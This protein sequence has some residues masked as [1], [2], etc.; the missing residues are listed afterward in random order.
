MDI[1]QKNDSEYPFF[2]ELSKAD[3]N[4]FPG[5]SIDTVVSNCTSKEDFAWLITQL[6]DYANDT[7]GELSKVIGKK[8]ID[9]LNSYKSFAK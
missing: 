8:G 2:S 6:K 1:F 3:R 5:Y 7:P 9:L 4:N